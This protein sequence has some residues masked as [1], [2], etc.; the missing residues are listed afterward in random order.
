VSNRTISLDD[1]LYQYLLDHS[2]REPAILQHLRQETAT[3]EM[4][5]MQISPEQGQFMQLLLKMLGAKR[6]IEV[7][8][9]TG[10]SSLCMAMA[11]PDDGRIVACDIH[12]QWTGIARRYWQEAGLAH[13]VELHLAPALDT[14]RE[15]IK[16]NQSGCF[17]FAFIDADKVNYLQ[18][19][20]LCLQLIRPGGLIAI[21]NVLWSGDVANDEKVDDDTRAIRQ[22][23]TL[24]ARD[25]RVEISMLPVG[26]GLSLVRRR[27][28]FATVLE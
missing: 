23:N 27:D 9:F 5:V 12:P 14:L 18:Y 22:L 21:D 1:R 24:L 2:L 11:L 20:E 15:L 8:V 13:K 7:G 3:L 28:D 16:D 6:V 10:Y 19:Y 26:D 17:D 25:Q 4:A